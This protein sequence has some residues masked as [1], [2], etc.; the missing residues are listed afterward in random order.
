MFKEIHLII[1]NIVFVLMVS[2]T[3]SNDRTEFK[4]SKVIERIANKDETPS[5]ATGE[6][7]MFEEGQDVIFANIVSMS[8]NSRPEACM[9]AS[10]LEAR[11]QML[12]HIKDNIVAS[13]QLNEVGATQDPAYESLTAFFSS[14]KISGSKVVGRYW[15]RVEESDESRERVLRLQCATK[16]SVKKQDLLKQMREAMGVSSGDPKVREALNKATTGFIDGLSSG[17]SDK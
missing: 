12:R 5:W 13:G 1:L 9:K 10:E 4:K 14:G 11:S 15:Q 6:I 7:A 17:E 16:V 8:G 3:S 2:C